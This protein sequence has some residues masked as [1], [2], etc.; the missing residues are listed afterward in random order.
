MPLRPDKDMLQG[1]VS[2]LVSETELDLGSDSVLA[3]VLET[4]LDLV[5]APVSALVKAL[6]LESVVTIPTSL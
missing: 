2:D 1:S 5:L 3:P 6:A 4:V